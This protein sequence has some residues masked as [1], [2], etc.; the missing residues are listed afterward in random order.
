MNSR[1]FAGRRRR[2]SRPPRKGDPRRPV[3]AIARSGCSRSSPAVALGNISPRRARAQPPVDAVEHL[4]VVGAGNATRLIRQERFDDRPL[5]IG[6]LVTAR[7]T[8]LRSPSGSLESPLA[9]KRNLQG[10]VRSRARGLGV[11]ERRPHM[12]SYGEVDSGRARRRVRLQ[13]PTVE[14]AM[15]S[16]AERH[17]EPTAIRT[18]LGDIFVSLELSRSIWLIR[19]CCRAAARRCRNT[20]YPRGTPLRF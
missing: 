14:T 5:E 20:A 15:Q 4:A 3:F 10:Y 13:L 11:T 9:Q 2:P 12:R 7:R 8:H 6:Q 16:I 17:E 19:R 1:P 18:N